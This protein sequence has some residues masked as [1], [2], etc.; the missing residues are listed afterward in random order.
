MNNRKPLGHWKCKFCGLISITKKELYKHYKE[1]HPDKCGTFR[2]TGRKAWNSGKTSKDDDRIAKAAQTL[3]EGYKSGRLKGSFLGKQHT[4]LTKQKLSKS[5]LNASYQR[6][7]KNTQTYKK[8]DGSIVKLDSSYE[9]FVAKWLDGHNIEWIRPKPLSWIDPNGKTHHYFPD[10]YV[11][12]RNI[13]LD[14]KNDYCFNMQREKINIL[15]CTYENI[16]F[17]KR[18]D[19]TNEYLSKLLL[20]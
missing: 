13:Y 20:V 11:P 17:L 15:M 12:S 6:I 9:V 10:F 2:N 1:I 18:S 8:T 19:L 7:C 5:A 16:I 14:P 3:R 4:D